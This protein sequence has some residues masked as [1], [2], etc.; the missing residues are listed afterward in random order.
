MKDRFAR[1]DLSKL[2]ASYKSEF[3]E[4]SASTYG[5]TDDDLNDIFA[6][7]FN[8]MYSL[9][10]KKY[11]DAI[12]TGGTI[13]KV[14]PP[15]Q[16][17]VKPK[18]SKEPD[19]VKV[20]AAMRK[21]LSVEDINIIESTLVNDEDSSDE[22]L[23]DY[24]VK[25]TGISEAQ[26]KKWVAL[27]QKYM[28]S[29]MDAQKPENIAAYAGMTHRTFDYSTR[30]KNKKALRK[31][32]DIVKTRD[33]KEFDRRSKKNVGKTFYDEN[34]KAWK[35]KGY[36]AKL[37]VCVMEDSEGKEITSCLK[38]MYTTNPVSKRE[39]G[40]LVDDC[41]DT[42][43]EAGFTVKEHKAGKKRIKRSV[44]RPEKEIIKERVA[45]TFTPIMKDISGSEEKDEKNKDL[46]AAINRV[47]ALFTKLF[48]R[49]SNL[50][51]DGKVEAIEKIEKLLKEVLGE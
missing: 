36:N 34:G 32:K 39:K 9:V 7:N 6:E 48:N 41:K 42:L 26:A 27:R 25:E 5:F 43:K 4:M 17:V 19:L 11:P 24:I 29:M 37:D 1:L 38:D 23:V 10:E 13:K 46:I 40:N 2:P 45:D 15:K 44:P 20:P 31:E 12:K 8:D 16:K 49:L 21:K 28:M 22:E 51:D 35:C 14:K 50:A 33:D 18:K 3:D 47:Q 30:T